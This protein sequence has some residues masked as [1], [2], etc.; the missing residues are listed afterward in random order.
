[1]LH[2]LSFYGFSK[3]TVNWFESYLSGRFNQMV[4][5]DATCQNQALFA[6]WHLPQILF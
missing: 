3:L 5:C 1:M 4:I 2:K 6:I